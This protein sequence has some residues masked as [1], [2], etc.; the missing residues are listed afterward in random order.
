M[1]DDDSLICGQSQT[2]DG[3]SEPTD[4]QHGGHCAFADSFLCKEY[5]AVEDEDQVDNLAAESGHVADHD[6]LI[7]VL[8]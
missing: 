3:R 1:I 4:V 8:D 5:G 7:G 2:E 6:K